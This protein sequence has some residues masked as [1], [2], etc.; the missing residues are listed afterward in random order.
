MYFLLG[1]VVCGYLN[2][3]F[4]FTTD[5]LLVINPNFPFTKVVTYKLNQIE[6]IEIYR[7]LCIQGIGWIFFQSGN[8]VTITIGGDRFR[9]YCGSLCVD[10]FDED[11]TEKTMDDFH[12]ALKERKIPAQFRL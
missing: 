3:T 9:Y 6:N 12:Y 1:Y 10:T 11:I 4:V 8:Y 7:S 2:N 5:K